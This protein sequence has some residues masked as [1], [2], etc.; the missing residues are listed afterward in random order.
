MYEEFYGFTGKPFQILPNPKYLYLSPTHK[1]ALLSLEYGLNENTGFILLTGEIGCGKTTL[2]RHFLN[3]LDSDIVP[4]V[5]FNTNIF[6]DHL[7]SNIL[8]SFGLESSEGEKSKNL[9]FLNQFL[10]NEYDAGRRAMLIIDEAQNLTDENLEDIRMLSNFQSDDQSLLQIILVGQPE[11][12]IMLKHPSL[13]PFSQRIAVNS[14]LEALSRRE[15]LTYIVFRLEKAGGKPDIF[16]LE[17]MDMIYEAS[18]GV[19]RKINLLCDLAL[20]F[21][22][23]EELV[24]IGTRIIEKAIEEH[25]YIGLYDKNEYQRSRASRL[26]ESISSYEFFNRLKK[27]ENGFQKLQLHVDWQNVEKERHLSRY[28]DEYVEKLKEH[29]LNETKRNIQIQNENK[30]LK[31]KLKELESLKTKSII[32]VLNETKRNIRIQNENKILKRK[33]K[34]L[35]SIKAKRLRLMR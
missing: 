23:T 2:I 35:E 5:I 31:R 18:K 32:R 26:S 15:T 4:A 25:G 34:E 11:L 16:T 10:I 22:F 8:Q 7:H 33:L 12:R 9:R 17:A 20:L 19:P 3:K 13:A 14:H 28:K 21:G 1:N 29:L 6:A 24:E 27:L 30:I